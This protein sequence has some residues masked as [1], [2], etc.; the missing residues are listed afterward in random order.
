MIVL[1]NKG[2]MVTLNIINSHNNWLYLE[3]AEYTEIKQYLK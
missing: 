1:M 2:Y 3:N